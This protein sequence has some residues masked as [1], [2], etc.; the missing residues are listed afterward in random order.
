MVIPTRTLYFLL[1]MAVFCCLSL[2][3]NAGGKGKAAYRNY[4][5]GNYYFAEGQVKRAEGYLRRAHEALPQQLTFALGYALCLGENGSPEKGVEVLQRIKVKP[6]PGQK[7]FAEQRIAFTHVSAIVRTRA[8]QSNQ[9]KKLIRQAIARQEANDKYAHRRLSAMYNL[10]GYL[11]AMNQESPTSHGGLAPHSHL[12]KRSLESAYP[13]LYQA[14]ALDTGRV[15]T[16]SSLELVADTLELL[17]DVSPVTKPYDYK[18]SKES[19]LVTRYPH[20]PRNMTTLVDFGKYDEVLFLVDISGSMVMEQV[21]CV[22]A[23]RFT[24]MREAAQLLVDYLPDS[25]RAGLATIGGDCGTEPTWWI[26]TDSLSRKDL[27]WEIQYLNPDG[28]TPLLTTLVRAPELFSDN[29]NTRKGIFFISDGENICTVPGLDICDWADRLP[30]QK[31]SIN[32]LTFLDRDLNNSGAFAEYACLTD[33]SGGQV[34][35]LDPLSCT[36]DDFGFDLADRITFE[37]PVLERVKCFGKETAPLW[38]VYPE[39]GK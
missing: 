11:E 38:A 26:P 22:G 30:A 6:R 23:D 2:A 25:T 37:L 8:G 35:Y 36:V 10:A 18:V 24:V 20:L 21:T 14:L 28:T 9:A 7:D 12:R 33:R 16:R 29:P 13:F 5:F 3:T 17:K 31:I 1:L 39:K 4:Y 32:V 27:K 19:E 15:D 34:R